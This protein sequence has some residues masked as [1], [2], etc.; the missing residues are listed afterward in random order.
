[1]LQCHSPISVHLTA[2][3]GS[4]FTTA[5]HHRHISAW[6]RFKCLS[7][8]LWQGLLETFLHAL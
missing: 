3:N 7:Y 1:V 4:V 5:S 8:Y 6:L 2:W